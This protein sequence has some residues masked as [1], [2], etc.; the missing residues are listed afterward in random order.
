MSRFFIV[1]SLVL[2]TTTLTTVI[3]DDV[4]KVWAQW[5]RDP[6]AIAVKAAANLTE[7][8]D[9]LVNQYLSGNT[10]LNITGSVDVVVSGGG[11][12]DAYFMGGYMILHRL[13]K[14]GGINIPRFRGPSAGG[15][16]PFELLLRGENLTLINRLAYSV[17]EEYFPKDFYDNYTNAMLVEDRHLRIGAHYFMSTYADR[18]SSVNGRV[19]LALSCRD[20]HPKLVIVSNFTSPIQAEHAFIATGA[21]AEEYDG[22]LCSDGG[23]VSGP[24]Q[25]PLFQDH[26]RDQLVVNLMST[27]QPPWAWVMTDLSAYVSLIEQGQNE[28]VYFLKTG[29]CREDAISLC[30]AKADVKTLVCKNTGV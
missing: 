6:P 11:S 10:T 22:M 2:T 14:M 4:D 13:E 15:M 8:A 1:F 19:S 26:V 27:D 28:M 17:L 30:P 16:M 18:L 29:T 20:P 23:D 21:F 25:T 24:N 3:A 12:L 9:W 7:R 5:L